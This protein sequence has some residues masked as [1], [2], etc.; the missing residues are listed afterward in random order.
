MGLKIYNGSSWSS[1]ASAFK[2]YNGSSWTDV[3]RGY[4]YDGSQ[5]RQFH[6]EAPAATANPSISYV[7]S[8]GFGLNVP[9]TIT[10][11]SGTWTNSPT[12][13]A[14][15]W[16]ARGQGISS[17]AVSGATSSTFSMTG[18]YAGAYMQCAVTATN[19]RGST[20]AF[21]NELGPFGPGLLTGLTASK[22]GT[23]TVFV[24]WNASPGA[25]RYYVQAS[26]P[27]AEYR[28]TSTSIT[29]TGLPGPSLGL[30]VSAETTQ[31][32]FSMGLQGQGANA[33]VSGLP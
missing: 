30:Y 15:Q 10:S 13:Y 8:A 6:P 14:Y 12:S 23:G 27:F 3:V 29:I 1:Q 20:T 31:W 26:P 21:S 4:V 32:G 9:G 7:G 22:T 33:S 25:Q 5:W 17:S 18:T 24:S 16:Y 28:P 19:L 2:L 11:T